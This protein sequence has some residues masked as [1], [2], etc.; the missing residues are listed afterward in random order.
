M[1]KDGDIS[2]L[3]WDGQGSDGTGCKVFIQCLVNVNVFFSEYSVKAF[4]CHSYFNCFDSNREVSVVTI[5]ILYDTE[6]LQI[7]FVCL[8]GT[9]AD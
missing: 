8:A 1:N 2:T 3:C 6:E 9:Y 5:C 4:I 7:H